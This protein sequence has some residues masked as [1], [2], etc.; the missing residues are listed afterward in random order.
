[1]TN[2]CDRFRAMCDI[3]LHTAET[4]LP[5]TETRT[6]LCDAVRGLV[7][8]DSP[9]VSSEVESSVRSFFEQPPAHTAAV[10]SLDHTQFVA[11]L[12]LSG[13]R[14][15]AIRDILSAFSSIP[16]A[17]GTVPGPAPQLRGGLAAWL[18]VLDVA[19]AACPRM[20]ACDAARAYIRQQI[21]GP[22]PSQAGP[23]PLQ[24][25]ISSILGAFPGFS[26]GTMGT[27]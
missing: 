14:T 4:H 21:G 23:A 11:P 9:M 8:M 6:Q 3:I 2:V 22:A 27:L 15:L 1:M 13:G 10:N 26:G 19:E 18:A 12:A 17:Y 24:S 25:V 16:V 7:S 5:D 20:M